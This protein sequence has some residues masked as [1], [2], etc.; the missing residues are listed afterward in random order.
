VNR[1]QHLVA[2]LALL[3]AR[4]PPAEGAGAGPTRA[5]THR[6]IRRRSDFDVPVPITGGRELPLTRYTQPEPELTLFLERL[7]LETS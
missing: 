1:S 6:E 2:S 3:S 7:R 5:S 4:H